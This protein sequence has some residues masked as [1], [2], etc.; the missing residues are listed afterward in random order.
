M[1][2]HDVPHEKEKVFVPKRYY[3]LEKEKDKEK[4]KY[5][6]TT[7]NT[8]RGARSYTI[9]NVPPINQADALLLP[10]SQQ[11]SAKEGAYVVQS[12][13]DMNNPASFL[14]G[15]GSLYVEDESII[16]QSPN[17]NITTVQKVFTDPAYNNVNP[18]GVGDNVAL[19]KYAKTIPFHRK[20]IIIT[21]LTPESSFTLNYNALVERVVNQQD[22]DLVVLAR[23]SP[24]ED[25]IATQLYT[26]ITRDMPVGCKF[27][28]N[29]FG[30]W[31]LG[32]VDEVANVVSSI[33]KPIMAAVS[34][35]QNS[36]AGTVE[37][38]AAQSFSAPKVK[39]IKNKA[40][41][42]TQKSK[43]AGKIKKGQVVSGPRL[44]TGKF[45]SPEAKAKRKRNK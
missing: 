14:D 39:M 4:K 5:L 45:N 38:A 42:K 1:R 18:S 44:P 29:G 35:Y 22:T 21:G 36:R 3:V 17:L 11:W 28:D 24:G 23:P 2:T 37:Q 16:P 40:A 34:G 8:S 30:D 19:F 12:M 13:S 20:G 15:R 41:N 7:T 33:G 10:G 25:T 27:S 32:V 6:P 31:F 26:M 43:G 9:K